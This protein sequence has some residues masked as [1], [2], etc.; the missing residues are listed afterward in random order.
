MYTLDLIKKTREYLDYLEKHVSAVMEAFV[1]VKEKLNG[2]FLDAEEWKCLYAHICFHDFSKLT[3]E[4]FQAYR[5]WFYPVD[6]E[7]PN[8]ELMDN[9]WNHHVNSNP[10]HVFDLIL[11]VEP[12]WKIDCMH[13][14]CDWVAMEKTGFASAYEY[15][16]KRKSQI[17]PFLYDELK[18]VESIFNELYGVKAE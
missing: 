13:L 14:V 8:K 3:K 17:S 7:K 1:E 11:P 15:F 6:R 9:A 2:K 10:H 12:Q 16:Q 18:F 5:Q 4:E